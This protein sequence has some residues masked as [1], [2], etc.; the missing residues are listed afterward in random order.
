MLLSLSERA[1]VLWCGGSGGGVYNTRSPSSR[2]PSSRLP[3][4]AVVPGAS[5]QFGVCGVWF[6]YKILL[7]QTSWS[8]HEP[9]R[10]ALQSKF[11]VVI[12]FSFK[13]QWFHTKNERTHA[14]NTFGLAVCMWWFLMYC[15][16]RF[17]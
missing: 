11:D 5:G 10:F 8:E 15:G 3:K 7:L 9:V 16:C 14:K 1:A 6:V 12:T 4:G 2:M 17:P 13:R